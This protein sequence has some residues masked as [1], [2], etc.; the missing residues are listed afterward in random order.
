MKTTELSN[1][2]KDKLKPKT[3]K[4]FTDPKGHKLK[5]QCF[6][7]R[8]ESVVIYCPD[9]NLNYEFTKNEIERM[10]VYK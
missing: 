9:C 5:I 4:K 10:E 3:E 1:W 8:F 6:G 2:E 7:G